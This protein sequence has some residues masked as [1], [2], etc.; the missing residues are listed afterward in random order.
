MQQLACR[1]QAGA[2]KHN[3]LASP[4]NRRVADRFPLPSFSVP[5]PGRPTRR[6]NSPRL[7]DLAS[8]AH[9]HSFYTASS[10]SL[11]RTRRSSLPK[12]A[13]LANSVAVAR[14]RRRTSP[15]PWLARSAEATALAFHVLG[16]FFV[17]PKST[18]HPF[19]LL[20]LGRAN[21]DFTA[22]FS[23]RTCPQRW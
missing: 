11:T 5:S 17:L 13:V 23:R 9:A 14:H 4:L 18:A 16:S 8:I 2:G 6:L 20:S 21:G 1:A 3:H 12:S 22:E 15:S 19:P 7:L 10:T